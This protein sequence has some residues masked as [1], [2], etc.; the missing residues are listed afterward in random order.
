MR[1]FGYVAHTFSSAA[2]FLW[3]GHVNSTSCVIT[4][5][6]MPGMSGIDL[7]D[8]LIAR[9]HSVPIIVI[10]AFP[11]ESV[12]TRVLKAGAVCFLRKPFDG[13]ILIECIDAALRK[14]NDE[15]IEP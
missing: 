3:S 11:E 13:S 12:R 15:A 14:R 1:S 4:D 8:L 5:V 7:L 2:E 9:G 6:Q 10:T